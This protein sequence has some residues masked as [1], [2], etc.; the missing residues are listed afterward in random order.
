MELLVPYDL[1]DFP[2]LKLKIQKYFHGK[3]QEDFLKKVKL[4]KG[5]EPHSINSV[6]SNELSCVHKPKSLSEDIISF[7][8]SIWTGLKNMTQ[9]SITL[10]RIE[11]EILNTRAS[12]IQFPRLEFESLPMSG[13]SFS[14]IHD[15][16]GQEL[17]YLI[18]T[19]K[20]NSDLQDNVLKGVIKEH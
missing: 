8:D 1:D 18:K 12:I 5:P 15:A 14:Q 3:L 2:D 16:D 6:I 4:M 7:V 20:H 13:S 9:F 17:K 10:E 11:N 19:Y